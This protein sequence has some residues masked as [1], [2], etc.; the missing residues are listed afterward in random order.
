[1]DTLE[2]ANL[3]DR[4]VGYLDRNRSDDSGKVLS[5]YVGT[6]WGADAANLPYDGPL[7]AENRVA[8]TSLGGLK[9]FTAEHFKAL[10]DALEESEKRQTQ[11]KIFTDEDGNRF[12]C[13]PIEEDNNE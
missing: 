13:I 8:N 3:M 5:L 12:R 10:I 6:N 1:M 4:F 2:K 9:G 7:F 11:G